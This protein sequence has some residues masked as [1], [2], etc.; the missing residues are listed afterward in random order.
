[1]AGGD[2]P[3]RRFDVEHRIVEEDVGPE[4]LEERPL[5]APA[6]EQRLV[7]AHAPLAQGQDHTLVRGRRARRDE[8][9]ADRRTLD[10]ERRLD[11]VQGFEEAAERSDR[12][13]LAR[14][15]GLVAME[16]FEAFEVGDALG[17]VAE[18]DRIAV[19]GDAQLLARQ[20]RRLR[21]QDRRRGDPRGQRTPH[22][23]DV[24]REEQVG[25]EW[26][27]VVRGR[28]AVGE[29]GAHDLEPVVLDRVEDA[30]AGVGRIARQQDDLDARRLRRERVEAQQLL[31]E[32][33][34]DARREQVVL[35]RD[36]VARIGIE[37]LVLEQRVAVAE[38]E[39]R[40]RRDRDDEL[41]CRGGHG[42][43][44]SGHGVHFNRC[45]VGPCV[46]GLDRGL[47]RMLRRRAH[48]MCPEPIAGT[49]TEVRRAPD[50]LSTVR[51]DSHSL[52]HSG[53]R[54]GRVPEGVPAFA[55][56]TA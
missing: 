7:D 53:A 41:V 39:Q 42:F 29:R 14:A 10:R 44:G 20:L 19:E 13:R 11:A 17:V 9:R 38:V 40:A 43:G 51:R 3:A 23:L 33:K 25:T 52:K 12:E 36:L 46:A 22:V 35:V 15:L 48:P 1:M 2:V 32:R 45:E 16:R 49:R 56:T 18:D 4:R 5:A 50:A 8:G 34:R 6:K 28:R 31:H 54:P 37:A 30:Q 55:G 47:R 24:G 26:M 21:R 27:R